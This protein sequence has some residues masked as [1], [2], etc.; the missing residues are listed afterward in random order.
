MSKDGRGRG[1]EARG[2]Q[3]H[4]DEIEPGK[5]LVRAAPATG[6]PLAQQVVR[7]FERL[8]WRTPLHDRRLD[9]QHPPK[10]L[11]VPVDP[12]PGDALAG[13]ALLEGWL[14]AAGEQRAIAELD[15]LAPARPGFTDY[16][17]GFAWLRDLAATGER[18]RAAVVAETLAQRWLMAHGERPTEP[19]WRPDVAA[20]R[21]LML[22]FHAPLLL[23]SSNLVARS[24][25][26]TAMARGARH[27]DRT[28]DKAPAGAP[29]VLAWGSVVAA[30]LLLPGG[31]TRRS[32]GEDGLARALAGALSDDGGVVSRSPAQLL[33]VMETIG[34]LR[35]LY[36]S[37]RE[38]LPEAP[39]AALTRVTP[40]L[41]GSAMGDGGLASWQG[42]L[43][44][45]A[46]RIN[47][48]LQA[49]GAFGRPLRQSRDWGYQRLSAGGA[50][51]LVDA[52]PPPAA[53]V[54]D[55]GCAATLALEFSDGA[56]RLIVSCG[57][58]GHARAR[59][60]DAMAQ[61]L[62]TT[63][64]H[65]TLVI[66]DTNSTAL[67]PDGTLGRGVTAVELARQES[68]VGSRI[69]A[70]HDGYAR[71]FGFVH[72]RTLLLTADGGELRGE[73]AVLPAPQ[74]ARWGRRV[75]GAM[76]PLA[77]RFHLGPGVD[78]VATADAQA[79]MLRTPSGAFWQLRARADRLTVEDSVWSDPHGRL[80]PTRQIVI[81]S[82]A[83]AGGATIAWVLRR[84][85]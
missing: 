73:D 35:A 47:D 68:D 74:P 60:N 36:D 83:P 13:E 37:R 1:P 64:A 48:A 7:W 38:P 78:A 57:G 62:R 23:S 79:A 54:P 22:L 15:P 27:L 33:A 42:G 51:L 67:N 56:E 63:A 49:S 85:R 32:V 80:V 65:S 2:G 41:L 11:A 4:H 34:L 18:E 3:A 21:L 24:R 70:R 9:G 61:A 45:D 20:R 82:L 26:L 10:L 25:V 75:E 84:A 31:E 14:F 30:G 12:F 59:G 77:L 72:Q 5:R 39:A 69:E 19:A 58:A 6:A 71:R 16:L 46:M 55:G 50:V 43:P 40:T 29:R 28:A 8:T 76:T 66:A 52:A 17:H 44:L 53:L 81:D